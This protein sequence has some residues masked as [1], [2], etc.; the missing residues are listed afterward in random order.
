ML[1]NCPWSLDWGLL[2]VL[3][4]KWLG[5]LNHSFLARVGVYEF[6]NRYLIYTN[7]YQITLTISSI[8]PETQLLKIPL[9]L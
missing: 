8:L 5:A 9:M 4:G 3:L 2:I 1:A 6:V 7:K